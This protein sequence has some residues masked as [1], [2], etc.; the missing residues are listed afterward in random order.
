MNNSDAAIT[1]LA[2]IVLLMAVVAFV[3]FAAVNIAI[4]L[5]VF[6]VLLQLVRM[7]KAYG[8][9]KQ[10]FDEV[11]AQIPLLK[12]GE[13]VDTVLDAYAGRKV[14]VAP[15]SEDRKPWL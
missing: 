11:M 5:M 6:W 9:G 14:E 7:A 1:R 4:M 12:N 10:Y 2:T 13:E 8:E 15:E 3:L